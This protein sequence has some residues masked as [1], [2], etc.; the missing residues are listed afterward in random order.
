MKYDFSVIIQKFLDDEG[1]NKCTRN[2][3]AKEGERKKKGKLHSQ[4]FVITRRAQKAR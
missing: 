1:R 2:N 3:F 4:R